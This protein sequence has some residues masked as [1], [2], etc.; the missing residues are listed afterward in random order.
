VLLWLCTPSYIRDVVIPELRTGRERAGKTLDG[1]DVVPAVP[2]AL[3]EDPGAAYETMR[4]ELIPYFGLPFYRA[5][6][7]RSGYGE[8]IAGYDAA[9]G[10]GDGQAMAEAI[11][12]RFLGELGAVGD[13]D[14]VRTGIERYRAAGATS[15]CVGPVSRTDFSATLDAAAGA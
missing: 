12:T 5:M 6:L 9:A 13:R 10:S 8:E 11:S 4:R 7:E 15:P 3:V 14:A 2:S 1:F